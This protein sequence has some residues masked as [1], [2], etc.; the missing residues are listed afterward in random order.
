MLPS[1]Q[2]NEEHAPVAETKVNRP[3][4]VYVSSSCTLAA[5]DGPLLVTVMLYVMLLPG[6]AE[7][8]PLF[9]TETSAFCTTTAGRLTESLSGFGSGVAAELTEARLVMVPL[10]LAGSE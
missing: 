7:P 4:G 2:G 5:L 3:E 6:C 8:G 10:A 9:V 1:A